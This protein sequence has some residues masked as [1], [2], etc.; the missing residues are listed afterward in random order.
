MKKLKLML[1]PE[2]QFWKPL[3]MW[4]LVRT[5]IKNTCECDV[6]FVLQRY[7]ASPVVPRSIVAYHVHSPPTPPSAYRD[8]DSPS[9]PRKLQRTRSPSFRRK[10][11]S[12]SPKKG[13]V[14]CSGSLRPS[15]SRVVD[16]T[17][18][19]WMVYILCAVS[20]IKCIEQIYTLTKPYLL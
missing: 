9:T 1:R 19:T 15:W 17:S 18:D 7:A 14:C 11:R 20:L 3:G 5:V 12:R 6:M 4:W 8:I 13:W 2:S 16:V 10:H